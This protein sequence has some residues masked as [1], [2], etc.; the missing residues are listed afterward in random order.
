MYCTQIS[1]QGL[2][3]SEII[4][5]TRDHFGRIDP[6]ALLNG[7]F[8]VWAVIQLLIS[9]TLIEGETRS[10]AFIFHP[11]FRLLPGHCHS[12]YRLLRIGLQNTGKRTYQA[13]HLDSEGRTISSLIFVFLSIFSSHFF[14]NL[15]RVPREKFPICS[16]LRFVSQFFTRSCS[17]KQP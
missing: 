16:A 6:D 12:Q 11:S 7:F 1:E 4:S 8:P 15:I 17:A 13:S 5:L 3:K 9:C 2:S 14:D 10:H